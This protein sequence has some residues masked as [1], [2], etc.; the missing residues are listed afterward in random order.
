ME[1]VSDVG[2]WKTVAHI[3]FKF[4]SVPSGTFS[5]VSTSGMKASRLRRVPSMPGL[6]LARFGK[7]ELIKAILRQ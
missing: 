5:R 4:P 2:I 3:A 6:G 7:H 1:V